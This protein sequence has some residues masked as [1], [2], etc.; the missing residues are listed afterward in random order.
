M[1]GLKNG[2]MGRPESLRAKPKMK[3]LA[4]PSKNGLGQLEL[5]PGFSLL[6]WAG[7][8][9]AQS[10]LRTFWRSLVGPAQIGLN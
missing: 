10:E 9:Q 4:Q 6:G 7:L 3:H 8:G 1:G 2:F 5:G